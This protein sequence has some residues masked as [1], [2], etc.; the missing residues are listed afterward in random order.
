MLT[1]DSLTSFLPYTDS[2]KS[3]SLIIVKSELLE[4]EAVEQLEASNFKELT[5]TRDLEHGGL[6]YVRVSKDNA[7]DAYD[8]AAQFSTGQIT[9]FDRN[10]QRTT[11]VN[12]QYAGSGLVLIITEQL[13]STI[14]QSGLFLRAVAGL[15]T[16]I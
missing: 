10:A 1:I 12:P 8:I 14:E 3:V 2:Q 7:K 5:D 6:H 15:T 4:N 16:Q 11:W 9:F 13:L